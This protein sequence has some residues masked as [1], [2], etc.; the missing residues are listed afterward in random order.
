MID[1][2]SRRRCVFLAVYSP[3]H[4]ARQLYIHLY[5]TLVKRRNCVVSNEYAKRM[6]AY[7]YKSCL[8]WCLTVDAVISWWRIVPSENG[9]APEFLG[10]LPSS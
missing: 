1:R 3:L 8:V 10:F 2:L 5:H 6:V 4:K 7:R 9:A